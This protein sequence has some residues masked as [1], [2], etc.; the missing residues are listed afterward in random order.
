M[1]KFWFDPHQVEFEFLLFFSI[2]TL[3]LVVSK[4]AAKE[5]EATALRWIRAFKRIK[6][7]W[8]KPVAI[9]QSSQPTQSLG[10]SASKDV[11]A[12]NSEANRE[13]F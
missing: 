8:Q 11:I 4:P 12:K 10:Q 7:E 13:T 5:F 9:E 6:A 1:S 2:F 3:I